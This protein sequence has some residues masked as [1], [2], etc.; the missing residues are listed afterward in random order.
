[1]NELNVNVRRLGAGDEHLARA[2]FAGMAAAFEE[3]S[4]ALSDAYLRQLLSR[5]DLWILAATDGETP[6]GGLTAHVLPMTRAEE[7]EVFIY[8]LAVHPEYQRRGVGRALVSHVQ[9]LAQ[10]AGASSVFVPADNEDGHALEF[11]RANDG[12]PA[13]VTMFTFPR[14]A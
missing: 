6:L 11:Y 13:P 2:V 5:T 1:M 9:D 14:H 7:C 4:R 12:E 3:E 8:D 10:T